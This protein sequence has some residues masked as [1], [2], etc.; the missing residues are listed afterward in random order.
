[1]DREAH[2]GG[3]L[4]RLQPT[5]DPCELEGKDITVQPFSLRRRSPTI[6]EPLC[7]YL[8]FLE[9]ALIGASLVY[10][11]LN[12]HFMNNILS[13]VRALKNTSASPLAR[14]MKDKEVRNRPVTLWKYHLK[15]AAL[16]WSGTEIEAGGSGEKVEWEDT[17][18]LGVNVPFYV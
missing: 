16:A 10:R 13:D 17:R 3:I 6:P 14:L 7:T 4:S 18:W 15:P 5:S 11:M 9:A 8:T 2:T 12:P 1:M